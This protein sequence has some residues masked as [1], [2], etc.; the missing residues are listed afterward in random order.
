MSYVSVAKLIPMQEPGKGPCPSCLSIRALMSCLLLISGS[1]LTV[2][3]KFAF[4]SDQP[5]K[6]PSSTS[7][8]QSTAVTGLTKRPVTV[9]DSIQMTRLGDPSYTDGAPSKGIVAKFS[10]DGKQFLAILKKGNLEANTNEYS[11]VLFQTAEVFQSPE[12]RVL[13]TLASSSNRPAINNVLWL[14]DNDTIL[15]LGERP[16]EHTALYSLKCSSQEL[17]KLTNHAT[18]LTSFVTTANGDTVLYAA[19]NAVPFLTENVS[20]RGIAVTSEWVTDLIRG[21]HEGDELDDGALFLKQRGQETETRIATQGR[22]LNLLPMSLSPDGAHLLVQ[23]E[24]TRVPN[25]W[26]EYQ[27]R[28]LQMFTRHPAPNGGYTSVLQYELVDIRTGASEVLLDTPISSFGSEM[29]WS[30]DGKSVV[31]S[32]A[33]LPLNVDNPAERTLRKAHTFLV[34][35]KISSRELVKIS[36][37]DLKLLTWDPK[38]N[39]VACDA[40]RLDSLNGKTTPKVYFRK[41]GET[42][43]RSSAREQTEVPSRPD[44]VLDEGMNT[45]PRIVAIDPPTGRKS[46]LMDLNPQF[47]NLA[48]ARVEEVTWKDAHG[49][50]VKGGLYWPPDYVPGK[51]YPLILQTHGWASDRFWMDGPWAT[52]FAAQPLAGRGFFVLQVPDPDWHIAETSREAPRAMAAF[53]SAIDYLDRRELIDRNRVGITGFSRTYWY[54]TYTLTHSKHHFAAADL[55]DGVDYSYFEYMAFS[56]ADQGAAAEYDQIYGGPPF[57]KGLSQWLKR[58]PSFLMDKIQTPIRIQTLYPA[59]LLSDWHWYSGLSRLGKP[60][61]MIYIPEGT[62]ILEKPWDRMI[63][64]QGDVDWFRF[65]I[66]GEEDSDP[67]K[68][69]QYGRWRELRSLQGRTASS[70]STR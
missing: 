20:R 56:N 29:A 3:S 63:S 52:T 61:E 46:L 22:I 32:N 49:I 14:A 16:G 19:G 27:D 48:L 36:Q 25:T 17:R 65:W 30:P 9:A 55:A 10:P 31:V 47:L 4:C 21:S 51:K 2:C 7:T 45:P 33:Y 24:A 38:T 34:E 67:M 23:T 13:V 6:G 1:Y 15:F 59:S 70:V 62:H 12:P 11:L 39:S 54:V 40:G 28:F 50:E 42:W 69:E 37:E 64:Q 53:E 58:S 26:S 43:S 66:K 60:V 18:N 41:S 8:A 68:A 57:G 44:I 5:G 35:F